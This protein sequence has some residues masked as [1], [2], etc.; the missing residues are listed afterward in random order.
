M[1]FRPHK[2]G[3]DV[4]STTAKA[5]IYSP[6]GDLLFSDYKRHY[7]SPDEALALSCRKI[8]E[9][10]G[11][12][13]ISVALTGSA[14]MGI[15]EKN[16]LPF[17][18]ELAASAEFIQLFRPEIKTII[19]IGGEDSKIIFFQE[20]SVDLIMN[21]GCAG[22]TGAFIDQMATLFDIT[23]QELDSLAGKSENIYPVASRC[24]VFAK[25]DVQN[26]LSREIPKPDISA[27]IYN[28][29]ALQIKN[30]IMRGKKALAKIAFSG[31]PLTFLQNLRKATIESFSF[32]ESDIADLPNS[33]AL[34][35]MG[36]AVSS[37]DRLETTI[38]ELERKIIKSRKK[39]IV[40]VGS[41][42]PLF[43]DEKKFAEWKNEKE[44]A[45]TPKI[46]ISDLDG[47]DCYLGV[48]SGST[49]TKIALISSEGELAF[50][51]YQNNGGASIEAV[52]NGLT[53]LK[54]EIKRKNCDINIKAAAVAGYGEDL[55]KRAFN[56]DY[57]IVETIAH[58]R[59]AKEFDDK[60]GF[61][62]DIGGQDM[63]AIFIKNG[64][65]QNIEINEACSSGCGSFIETLADS[66]NYSV[67][68]FAEIACRAKKPCNLGTRCTVFMNSKVKQSFREGAEIED[69]SAGLAYSAIQ[70]CLHK[71]LKIYDSRELGDN[72]IVQGGTFKNFAVHKA[73]EEISGRKVICPEISELMGAYGA[74]LIA[75]D[76]A[77]SE[78]KTA[79]G[80]SLNKLETQGK[81]EIKYHNCRGCENNCRISKLIFENDNYYFTGNR[82]E[83]VFTNSSG[84]S[85]NKGFNL[86]DH[87]YK[88]IFEREAKPE[89][90]KAVIGI[91]RI[92]NI[93]ENY[94]FW[95]A[96][97]AEC[98]FEVKLSA[99]PSEEITQKG[100]GTIMSDNICLPAKS[101]NGHIIDLIEKGVDRIFFPIVNFEKD[102]YADADNAFNC[103]VVTG[104]P[105]VIKSSINPEKNYGIPFDYPNINFKRLSTL[106]KA[107]YNYFKELGVDKRN[108]E[109]AFDSAL[110]ESAD[111][112]EKLK[113]KSVEIILNAKANDK[114]IFVLGTRPYQI[115]PYINKRA[116]EILAEYGY[117]VLLEDSLPY[118]DEESL[119][120]MNVL[121]QWYFPNRIYKAAKWTCRH[122]NAEF[123]QLNSFGCGPDTVVI[124][125]IKDYM[126]S[127]GKIHAVLRVDEHSAP[128]SIKLRI[129]SL[130][131]SIKLKEENDEN[132]IKPKPRK[133][134][135]PFTK[136]EKDRLVLAPFFSPFHSAYV[137]AAFSA[138]GYDFEQL[139]PS[140][141]E[142]VELGLK[143]VNNEICYPATL[144]VGD[145]LKALKSGKY[146]D[147]KLAVGITQTGGQCRAS[148]YVSLIKKGLVKNGYSDIPVVG[149]TLSN[150]E[151]NYQPGFKLSKI[152][153]MRHAILG[154][155]Y[156]DCISRMYYAVASRE[157]NKG[158]AKALADRYSMSAEKAV[159]DMDKEKILG[160]LNDAVD[161]F[162]SIE[163]A[164]E[165]VPKIGI[166]G[167]IYVKY[168]SA[169]N[170]HVVDYL[171][172]K[173]VEPVLPPLI[174]LFT[175]WLVN[176]EI[177]NDYLIERKPIVKRLA[178]LLEKYYNKTDQDYESV[179]RKF[180][181][182][183]P[184]HSLRDLAAYA[185][186]VI[187]LSSHYFGEGWLIAADTL[188]LA[189]DG[190]RDVLCLQPFGCIANHIAAR[191][192]E[193]SLREQKSKPN[194][195]Y[196][197]IDAGASPV[198]L[199]NRL[200]LLLMNAR[201]RVEAEEKRI[202]PANIKKIF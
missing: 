79:G 183:L 112:R 105:N 133:T 144:L 122:K 130:I 113:A 80:F 156:G 23:L 179:M 176:V 182:N 164:K 61:V 191:G 55:I 114:K 148:N 172:D 22:G 100:A 180:K 118:G 16:G 37:C 15:S 73:F 117:D 74:A 66:L 3:I 178:N 197:D 77:A 1:G 98:G 19:D 97:F 146:D 24:G 120:D 38:G 52:R 47:K 137:K 142:S 53:K 109:I 45:K 145:L 54:K 99:P 168:N 184:K 2:M 49:T 104:Y 70:N 93:Y 51:H 132:A 126:E 13:E 7:G 27:S 141:D 155:L 175:Q 40:T 91:P 181:F 171:V 64:V 152:K 125:E 87:K 147:R 57:G 35:A 174:N 190:I 68:K 90:P 31:G 96:L 48:D 6:A 95:A 78:N 177:K 92:L 14:G 202:I 33:E 200:H 11:D 5:V 160:A 89:N 154:L 81:Y 115:D 69:I 18:Q 86:T 82:C 72:I 17:V 121:T 56:I 107:C 41:L 192:V 170:N 59:A 124:D 127:K 166:V 34:P 4:G 65:I 42:N 44:R 46:D 150:K 43:K 161:D 195:L 186:K 50:Y 36:A 165:N 143:Y 163:L 158:E 8:K 62:L 12:I 67:E 131:E 85:K 39:E 185:K 162:N 135:K 187:D 139:P 169:G 28:A 123:V 198:N 25:T 108:F 60:V 116:P 63:K 103:P 196:L 149:V 153:F 20:D 26:L 71:V 29:L 10:L 94:P 58:Y 119:D 128:G 9:T 140:D 21:D 151:L 75:K 106:K 167:E 83:R 102:E 199:H 138:L 30:S 136:D 194:V 111:F 32:E 88:L 76:K 110:N 129:R 84:K 134:T 188:A 173:G 201:K 189:N 157:K 159:A 101:A 193:K